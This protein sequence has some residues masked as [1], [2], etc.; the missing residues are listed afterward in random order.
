VVIVLN[1]YILSFFA[2][3]MLISV[4]AAV[5]AQGAERIA[6]VIGNSDYPGVSQKL[7]TPA[8]DARDLATELKQEGFDVETGENLTRDMMRRA[9]DRFYQRIKPGSVALIFF[10]GFG[11]QSQRSNYLIPIDAEI[12][13]EADVRA[14]GLSLDTI[15]SEVDSREAGVRIALIDASRNN[16]FERQFRNVSTGLAPPIV[17]DHALTGDTLI[18]YSIWPGSVLPDNGG[19]HGLFVQQ[20]VKQMRDVPGLTAKDMLEATRDRVIIASRNNQIPQTWSF[21]AKS[22][23]F[24]SSSDCDANHATKGP[25][26]LAV[27]I[28]NSRYP[29]EYLEQPVNDARDV[30]N[31]L[32]CEGFN[33]ETG[34]NLNGDAMRSTFQRLYAQIQPGSIA[35]V[36]FSGFGIQSNWQ[37]YMMPVDA[38]LQAESDVSRDGVNLDTVLDELHSRGAGLK[39]ALIDA[40]RQNPFEV[41]FRGYDKGLAMANP[42]NGTWVMYSSEPDSVVSEQDANRSLFVQE[43]LRQMR[44]PGLSA[45]KAFRETR[46][47]VE[48]ASSSKHPPWISTF[49]DNEFS[50]ALSPSLTGKNHIRDIWSNMRP[51]Q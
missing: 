18:M 13:N 2:A 35:L 12:S 30:A 24:S 47:N 20:L 33:V 9:L 27:V 21:K 15:L 34:E 39:I 36:F 46:A 29:E 23:S 38:K 25:K 42:P 51:I 44:V 16:P 28:G 19:D 11:I 41:R 1:R 31:E 48:Q 8:N 26:R 6:L 10:S 43:L 7:D 49:T 45:E 32:R 4:D 50:F 17:R 5:A 40:S 14:Q 3:L 22:F 37:T